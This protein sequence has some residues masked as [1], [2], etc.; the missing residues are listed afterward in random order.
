MKKITLMTKN[1]MTAQTIHEE[2]LQAVT[3]ISILR[4]M[5]VSS[6]LSN[7]GSSNRGLLRSLGRN[8]WAL[9]THKSS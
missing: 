8:L 5:T 4:V 2:D 3:D 1:S 6:M 9:N 7:K